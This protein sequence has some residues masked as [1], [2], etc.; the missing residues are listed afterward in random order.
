MCFDIHEV[1]VT[2]SKII[3]GDFL[4][5][6]DPRCSNLGLGPGGTLGIAAAYPVIVQ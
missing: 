5:P 2:P 4:C 6:S 3:K 1:D